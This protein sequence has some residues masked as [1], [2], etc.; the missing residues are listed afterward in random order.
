[1]TR[2]S[3]LDDLGGYVDQYGVV[4]LR[5]CTIED[6]AFA[7]L[8]SFSDASGIN[9]FASRTDGTGL[10]I[11]R[12][13][14]AV[15]EV[16]LAFTQVSDVNLRHLLNLKQLDVL[17]IDY[18]EMLTDNAMETIA[19][20]PSLDVLCISGVGFSSQ[21]MNELSI[22]QQLR[23]LSLRETQFN[24]ENSSVLKHMTKLELLTLE[25]CDIS[26]AAVANIA[27]CKNLTVL[28][29]QGTRISLLGRRKLNKDL[30]NTVI[31][32]TPDDFLN[33]TRRQKQ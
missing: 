1:M 21:V 25:D 24:D 4:N 32:Q 31:Y 33:P 13:M 3:E 23:L 27:G 28:E 29:I 18:C 20:F 9:L 8:G 16:N 12:N 2:K 19:G 5:D 22:F 26:D 15:R 14:P 10:S 7:V 6:D 17:N 30:P 11:L